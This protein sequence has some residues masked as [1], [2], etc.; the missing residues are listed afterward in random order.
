MTDQRIEARVD[1]APGL[2]EE[3]VN[4]APGLMSRRAV[5]RSATATVPTILTLTSGAALARSSNLIGT[6]QQAEGDV[7]CLDPR[8]TS[9]PTRTNPNVYDLG[10]PPYAEVTQFP[11]SYQ[12]RAKGSNKAMTP[13]E[14]C[15][16]R[17]PV[18]IKKAGYGDW[19]ELRRHKPGVMVSNAA[20]ASFGTRISIKDV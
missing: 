10:S 14:V 11:Q 12:Y 2:A 19:K 3:P 13:A 17:G 20:T 15:R 8:S 1:S 9:G 5:L 16:Y 7:L 4:E 18:E 6:I